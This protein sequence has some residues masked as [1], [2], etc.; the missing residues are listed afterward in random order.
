MFACDHKRLKL[1]FNEFHDVKAD[2][3]PEYGDY[4]LLELKDGRYTAG[5]W[6]PDDY[7]NKTV[8]AGYF[9][10]GTADSVDVAEVARWHSLEHYDLTNCLEDEEIGWINMGPSGEETYTVQ[11]GDFKS[12]EDGDFPKSEQFCLLIMKDGGLAAGRWNELREKYGCFIY[13]SA[14]ASHSME[15]VWAW[16]ALSSDDVFEREQEEE[17]EKLREEELNKNPVADLVKFKYGTDVE[18]YYKK[19]LEKLQSEYPWASMAQMKKKTK[20]VI[21]PRHGEYIFGMDWGMFRGEREVREWTDGTTADDIVDFLCEYARETVKN[22]DPEVKFKYG[23]DIE[24][25]L[26]KAFD[27]VKKDYRWLDRKIANGYCLYDIRQVN[28]DWEF[29]IKYAGNNEFYVDECTSADDF[30]GHVERN[31]QEA[32]IRANPVVE[33]YAVPREMMGKADLHG[34]YLERYEFYKLKTGDYKVF[35]QAGDR[36]TGGSREFFITPYCFEAKAYDEFLDR[37]LEI[38]PGGSFGLG[39]NDLL[40]NKELKKFMGY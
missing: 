39:K 1:S 13:A 35:V 22:S 16:T 20:Y 4:C 32:A 11:I 36:T 40:A 30:I 34:W 3:M 7:E 38:V 8:L 12:F 29:M 31:Y 14:L 2:D 5:E 23:Y 9:N 21:V 15:K 27:N 33:K 26:K 6:Y 25:Y 17:R 24:V 19:A 28:G 18:V 37:Y 10:R